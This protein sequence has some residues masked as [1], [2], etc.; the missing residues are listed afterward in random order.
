M[1]SLQREA[2]QRLGV[3]DLDQAPPLDNFSAAAENRV[4]LGLLLR[5]VISDKELTADAAMVRA[6]VEEL[7]AGYE[8]A[9]DMVNMYLSNPQVMQ[10][11]EPMIFEQLAIDWILE[12]GKVKAKKI[13]F[14][15]YMNA[16]AS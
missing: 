7:C 11:I 13:S 4:G 8:N 15:E 12:N 6:R 14:K 5:Q 2:M 3:E 16:P 1:H 9:E 10:Q